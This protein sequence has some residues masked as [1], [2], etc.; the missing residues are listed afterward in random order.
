[1]TDDRLSRFRAVYCSGAFIP[2]PDAVVALSLLFEKVHL[3]NNIELVRSFA[4]K[5]RLRS[6]S[7]KGTIRVTARSE[8]GE[9]PFSD[10]TESQQ[11]TAKYY[12]VWAM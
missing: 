5:Y 8:D 9:D 10:L 11:E 6:T 12:L 7:G 1:M 2:E 3:P 4:T